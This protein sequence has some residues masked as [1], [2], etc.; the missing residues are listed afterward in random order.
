[1]DWEKLRE[2]LPITRRWAFFSPHCYNSIAEIDRLIKLFK[3]KKG[4]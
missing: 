3:A 2:E 4:S 1:M